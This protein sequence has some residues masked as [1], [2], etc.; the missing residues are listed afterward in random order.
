MGGAV[1]EQDQKCGFGS[2]FRREPGKAFQH[3]VK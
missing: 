3:C 1:V 2:K